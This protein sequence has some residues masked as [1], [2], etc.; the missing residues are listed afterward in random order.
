MGMK[1]SLSSLIQELESKQ[2]Q[3]ELFKLINPQDVADVMESLNDLPGLHDL[4]GEQFEALLRYFIWEQFEQMKTPQQSIQ[5]TNEEI[6][7]QQLELLAERSVNATS[8]SDL[9]QLTLAMVEVYKLLPNK[10]KLEFIPETAAG[11]CK[12]SERGSNPS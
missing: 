7:R 4:S 6:L 9:P 1:K 11:K 5:V 10:K 3:K 8:E 12:N 2:L